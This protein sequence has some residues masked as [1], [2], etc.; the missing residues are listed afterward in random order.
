[1]DKL[2]GD[3]SADVRRVMRQ[4]AESDTAARRRVKR[5]A[6]RRGI[7]R[8]G[9]GNGRSMLRGGAQGEGLGAHRISRRSNVKRRREEMDEET[10]VP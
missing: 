9:Q 8:P 3:G 10:T 6:V 5:R 1:M 2:G 4:K 7:G